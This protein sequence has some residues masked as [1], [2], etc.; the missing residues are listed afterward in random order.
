MESSHSGAPNAEL[1]IRKGR[2]GA[3]AA[4]AAIEAVAHNGDLLWEGL[5]PSIGA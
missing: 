3:C 2:A 1:S 4:F 5:T